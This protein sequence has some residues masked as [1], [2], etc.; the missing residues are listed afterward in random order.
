MSM[1]VFLE[2]IEN[3]LRLAQDAVRR[4]AHDTVGGST[5]VQDA[6]RTSLRQLRADVQIAEAG[7]DAAVAEDRRSYLAAMFRVVDCW[8][9]RFDGLRTQAELG[10]MDARDDVRA[11]LATL[12]QALSVAEKHLEEA[13]AD[14]RATLAVVRDGTSETL[15]A[16]VAAGRDA[17]AVIERRWQEGGEP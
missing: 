16:L 13:R 8:R 10:R 11:A 7:L 5:A 6:L 14:A 9:G 1:P 3:D 17:I 4:F 12:E 2:P 15:D